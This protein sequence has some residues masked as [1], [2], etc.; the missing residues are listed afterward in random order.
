MHSTVFCNDNVFGL[1]DSYAEMMS[2]GSSILKKNDM[3]YVDAAVLTETITMGH[4][5]MNCNHTSSTN[6]GSISYERP[7]KN[8]NKIA[9]QL[10]SMMMGMTTN[11]VGKLKT[12]SNEVSSHIAC[13]I[14]SLVEFAQR[15]EESNLDEAT[16]LFTDV[17]SV[18]HAAVIVF[19]FANMRASRD[20]GPGINLTMLMKPNTSEAMDAYIGLKENTQIMPCTDSI[21]ETYRIL[22]DNMTKNLTVYTCSDQI[23]NMC[24]S[25]YEGSKPILNFITNVNTIPRQTEVLNIYSRMDGVMEAVPCSKPEE[26]TIRITPTINDKSPDSRKVRYQNPRLQIFPRLRWYDNMIRHSS[27]NGACID[28]YIMFK[29]AR[30]IALAMSD[31]SVDLDWNKMTEA[32]SRFE[33]I[34]STAGMVNSS[35]T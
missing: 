23:A 29:I 24:L 13:G 33:T 27:L 4:L 19:V 17:L 35:G 3:M 18:M 10:D 25:D 2:H 28:C 1:L 14:M 31:R 20:W 7:P 11:T 5:S 30:P 16:I 15:I 22:N 32:I 9:T 21:F 12:R 8:V 26:N 34:V 6:K